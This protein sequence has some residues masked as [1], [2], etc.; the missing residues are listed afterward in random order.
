MKILVINVAAEV[1]GALSILKQYIQKFRA[2]S[3]NEYVV[4]LST[5]SFEDSENVKFINLPWVKR[6][7]L[8]RLYFDSVYIKKL[9][10]KYNPDRIFSLQNK[11][12]KVNSIPQEVYFH[13]ALFICEKRFSLRESRKLWVYQNLISGM[14][15]KS[16]KKVDK[17][18][19]QADWIKKDLS[20]KW[21]ID[22]QKIFVERPEVNDVF[23]SFEFCAQNNE[24]KKLFYP[25]NFSMYKNHITLLKA[26][27]DIWEKHGEKAF[28]LLLTGEAE[29]LPE[30]CKQ[31]INAKKYP[32]VFLGKL[33][34]DEMK[35]Q[36]QDSVLV[37]PSYIETVG[38]PLMEAKAVGAVILASNCEY[39]RESVGNYDKVTYFDPFDVEMLEKAIRQA[40]DL[41]V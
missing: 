12:V 22:P 23:K 32:I 19:V 11:G 36:Y 39:A 18:Y 6:S 9:V 27:A 37:F 28:T 40:L 17:I 7:R 33:S 26:C 5:L 38:L 4:C 24:A 25:A 16:L 31:I 1:G 35:K 2:D 34:L 21:G 14:T 20:D 30:G 29:K 10:K 15:K 3:E 41:G 8:H 13:N